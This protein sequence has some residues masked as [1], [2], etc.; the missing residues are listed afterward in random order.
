MTFNSQ[1]LTYIS[2]FDQI[3]IVLQFIFR[4]NVEDFDD[5]SYYKDEIELP[6][7]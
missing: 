6:K 2:R 4:V 3:N 1:C 5:E 7:C